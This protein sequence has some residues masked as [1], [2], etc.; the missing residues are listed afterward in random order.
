[1]DVHCADAQTYWH[2]FAEWF[3][4]PGNGY[5]HQVQAVWHICKS[6]YCITVSFIPRATVSCSSI[7]HTK[8]W[9]L[10]SNSAQGHISSQAALL[11]AMSSYKAGIILLPWTILCT[12]HSVITRAVALYSPIWESEADLYHVHSL[13]PVYPVRLLLGHK[14]PIWRPLPNCARAPR[15]SD[16]FPADPLHNKWHHKCSDG[17]DDL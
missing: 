15:N 2:Y 6:P 1:M 4:Y 12:L 3:W 7:I 5:R 14:A 8:S 10:T 16:S 17:S 11:Y 13:K 9:E